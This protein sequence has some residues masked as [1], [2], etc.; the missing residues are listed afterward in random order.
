[1]AAS[2]LLDLQG[3]DALLDRF[4]A[5]RATQA[6]LQAS[7]A[8]YEVDLPNVLRPEALRS[9]GI[10]FRMVGERMAGD[11]SAVLRSHLK[12]RLSE[13]RQLRLRN[14]VERL[15][16][17]VCVIELQV[18]E[19]QLPAFLVMDTNTATSIIDRLV[20]GTGEGAEL[21][22]D[23]TA[24]EQRVMSDVV[25]PVVDAYQ[26]V[27]S[28]VAKL[29]MGWKRFVGTREEMTSYSPT[30]LYLTSRYHADVE[31]G[32]EWNFEFLLPLAEITPAIE[33]SASV[34]IQ[35]VEMDEDRRKKLKST[36]AEVDVDVTIELGSTELSLREV[37]TLAPGDVILLDSRPGE[38]FEFRVGGKAKYKG[39]IGRS[40]RSLAFKVEGPAG[41]ASKNA[42]EKK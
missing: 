29:T 22:R 3:I 28:G 38:L 42:Q 18:A 33:R 27:L 34:P 36:L 1:M 39:R 11:L 17:R 31:G 41:H 16:E 7:A 25:K 2:E 35:R 32:L 10:R 6:E 21:D 4:R 20:G 30:E 15:P 37:A 23:L 24:I 14:A 8:D 26:A 5:R 40:N 19:L 13:H 9:M 12:C